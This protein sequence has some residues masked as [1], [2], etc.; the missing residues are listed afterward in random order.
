MSYAEITSKLARFI[1]DAKYEDI[2][3]K[4]IAHAKYCI[5]DLLGC[6][7]AGSK[8]P[9]VKKLIEILR[10]N[11][12][13]G[14]ST[15]IGSK[16]KCLP[17]LAAFVNSFMSHILELDDVHEASI[18]HP[19]APVIPPAIAIAEAMKANGKDLVTAIVIGYDIEI[20]LG[21]TINPHHYM[22][23]HTTG[24]CGAFGATAT[25]G[26]L[27]N[28][29]HDQMINAL[30]LAGTLASGLVLTFGTIAKYLN[31]AHAAF[32]GILSAFLAKEGFQGP[33]N[34]L[35]HDKGFI[36]ATTPRAEVDIIKIIEDL[37]KE[38]KI[39]TNIIKLHASCGHTH[40]GI[41]GVLYIKD[42]YKIDYREV[43]KIIIYTYPI[44]FELTGKIYEPKTMHEAMFSYPYCI[45]AALI[46][47]KVGLDEFTEDKLRNREVLE[48]T[49]K[50]EVKVDPR[51]TNVRLGKARIEVYL[52][53][54]RILTHTV[55]APKGYPQNPASHEEIINKYRHLASRALSYESVLRCEKLVLDLE[56]VT[57]VGELT[58][59]LG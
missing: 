27:L 30:G 18:L 19:A 50:I 34:V 5:L 56:N 21:E 24:T 49:K 16:I 10:L 55:D 6:A 8:E 42:K 9:M 45:A 40:A 43:R 15:I 22:Y 39:L 3:A 31:P 46:Y 17:Y 20:R 44:A 48:I 41:D 23:W 25:V 4:V 11:M 26:K 59:L 14:P 36:R 35:E 47:G 38:Y 12:A 32:V 51:Y 2:P 53:D 28:L 52:N 57:D 58:K 54:G 7:L 33:I 37:G 13:S 1:I 29:D